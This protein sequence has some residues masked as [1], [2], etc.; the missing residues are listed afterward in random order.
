M[1]LSRSLADII[2]VGETYYLAEPLSGDANPLAWTW[3]GIQANPAFVN[4]SIPMPITM[5]QEVIPQGYPGSYGFTIGNV[6]ILA[7]PPGDTTIVSD[8]LS[9]QR[10][11]AEN[12]P[13]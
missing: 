11:F 9:S 10:C 5:N 4:G 8:V 1:S 3:S 6:S 12:D 7:P 2:G 13:V